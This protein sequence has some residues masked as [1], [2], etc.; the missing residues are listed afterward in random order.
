MP[1]I[2]PPPFTPS[3]LVVPHA[4]YMYSGYT[5][6]LA[7]R[8]LGVRTGIERVV[9]VGPSHRVAFEG[10][11][12]ALYDRYETPCG[13]L[14]IDLTYA[15]ALLHRFPW[16]IFA[17]QAHH[18]HSTEVQ[19]PLI[20]AY[21]PGVHVIEIVYGMI[22]ASE[23]SK[24]MLPILQEH[25]SLLVISTDLSHFYALDE[26]NRLDGYCLEA[27]EKMEP[28]RFERGCEACGLAGM[29]AML[30]A[31][32]SLKMRSRILDYRTSAAVSHDEKRV[33][34]YVSALVG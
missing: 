6:A 19:M 15:Q 12:V 1:S 17:P 10:A 2:S 18:E 31:A 25:S 20:A 22:E 9:V 3:A 34:G 13:D 27:L 33:V 26:A 32:R 5:A 24:L 30:E 16:L 11:S 7:Y 14:M 28:E 4:G 29:S 23:L 21:L 8:H